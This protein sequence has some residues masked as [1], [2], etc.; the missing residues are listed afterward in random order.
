MA[1]IWPS[2]LPWARLKATSA[3]LAALSISSRHSRITTGLRRTRMPPAPMQNTIALTPRYQVMFTP[4][5][6]GRA[7]GL[8]HR[9]LLL[10]PDRAR[11]FGGG[12][13]IAHADRAR[14]L[15]AL[16]P[17]GEDD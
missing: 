7:P 2:M 14:R 15:Q 3:R 16:P 4:S 5:S 17:A 11:A 8:E 12:E 1:K 10:G 6:R 13:Q 9:P